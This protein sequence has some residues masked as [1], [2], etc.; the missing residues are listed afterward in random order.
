MFLVRASIVVI[1]QDTEKQIRVQTRIL[2]TSAHV[3][4]MFELKQLKKT[5]Q[6]EGSFLINFAHK[7]QRKTCAAFYSAGLFL[8]EF[9]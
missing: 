4:H 1:M 8:C 9:C 6:R 5:W 3:G 2:E 7:G